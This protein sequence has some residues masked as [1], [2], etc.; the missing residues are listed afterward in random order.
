MFKK[1]SYLAVATTA[2][3]ALSGCGTTIQPLD[4]PADNLPTSSEVEHETIFTTMETQGGATWGLDRIDGTRDGSYTYLS[5]G[6]GVRIYIVDTGVDASHPDFGSRVVDGFDAFGENLDQTDC[7][8][9]GTHVAG[10]AAGNYFGVAKAATIVPVRVLNCSGLGNTTTL[11]AGI[12]WILDN[13]PAGVPAIVNMSLGGPKDVLV[14]TAV[15]KLIDAGIVVTVAA[16][17]SNV[18]ACTFSP[19]SADGV[20]AVGSI[21]ET[22]AK[23]AFSNWG[24]CVDIFAPGSKISSDSPFNHGVSVQKSGTSQASPFVAGAIATYI[25]NGKPSSPTGALQNVYAYSEKDVVVDGGSPYNNVLNVEKTLEEPAPTASPVV[26]PSPEPVVTPDP[27]PEPTADPV[28]EPAPTIAPTPEPTIEPT[29]APEPVVDEP[30]EYYVLATQNSSG[31]YGGRL[32]WSPI[33]G[34]SEYRIFKKSS[35]RPNW[36]LFWVETDA[37]YM[38]IVDKPGSIAI[39]SITAIV[40]S[41]EIELGEFRYEPVK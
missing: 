1:F 41:Q 23:S 21:T 33:P 37:T 14:N 10:I 27:T 29:P 18:D 11:T 39:Y 12:D 36:R 34:V 19:A 6:A 8:G 32:E 26:D 4:V 3:F 15:G 20:I 5:N 7:Q 2:L 13:N 17:N 30:V 9:H 28:V 38:D 31:S 24:G 40:G 35:I 25:S 16:G 22:D